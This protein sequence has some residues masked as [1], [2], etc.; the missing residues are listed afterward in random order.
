MYIVQYELRYEPNESDP[1]NIEL[2]FF[3]WHFE[4]W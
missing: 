4:F 1:P 2:N 3:E